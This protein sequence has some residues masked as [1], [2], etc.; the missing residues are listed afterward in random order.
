MSEQMDKASILNE[1]RTHYAA[2]EEILAPLDRTQMTTAGVISD[3][4]IKDM[5]AHI[6]SWH[7]RLLAWLH[8]AIRNEEPAISGPDSVEEMDALNAQFFQENKS[9]SLTEV[10]TDF[11]TTHQQIMDIIQAM[12]EEELINPDRFAWA[13]G[14][15]LWQ[16]IAGDTY[17]HYQEHL[18]QIQEW[19]NQSR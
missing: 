7:H 16:V 18:K 19:L 12:S 4:S 8:A 6:A 13:Q 17:E 2:L 11:R 5:L 1:M 3:W 14:E 15:P 10:L 9:R